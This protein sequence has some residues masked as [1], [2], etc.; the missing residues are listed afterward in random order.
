MANPTVLIDTR[1]HYGTTKSISEQQQTSTN[2]AAVE[3]NQYQQG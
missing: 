2:N 1:I 3:F